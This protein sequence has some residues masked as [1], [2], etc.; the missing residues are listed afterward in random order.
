MDPHDIGETTPVCQLQESYSVVI[1][2]DEDL[3]TAILSGV[4]NDAHPAIVPPASWQ[5]QTGKREKGDIYPFE[6]DH[7]METEEVLQLMQEKGF[8][9]AGIYALLALG[10]QYPEIQWECPVIA[11]GSRWKNRDGDSGVA[12]LWNNPFGRALLMAVLRKG[13]SWL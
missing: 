1:D 7:P 13:W 6:I 8:A 10:A 11:L 3:E 9:P 4:Y 2:Y 5:T 12:Y